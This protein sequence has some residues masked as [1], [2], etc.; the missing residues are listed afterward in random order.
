M[1]MLTGQECEPI[2]IPIP[3]ESHLQIMPPSCVAIAPNEFILGILQY[4]PG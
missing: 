4:S 2:P 1:D 3:I